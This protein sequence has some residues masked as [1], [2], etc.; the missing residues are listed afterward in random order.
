M[1]ELVDEDLDLQ[2]P[3]ITQPAAQQRWLGAPIPTLS[4]Y[5]RFIEE[6]VTGAGKLPGQQGR[7]LCIPMLC[8][9]ISSVRLMELAARSESYFYRIPNAFFF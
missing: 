3:E 9:L 2:A 7:S 8:K 5:I 4:V 1:F 6:Y